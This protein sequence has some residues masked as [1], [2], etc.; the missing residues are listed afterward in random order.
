VTDYHAGTLLKLDGSGTIVQ[1]VAVGTAPE[2]PI[3]DGK[4]IWVPNYVSDSVSV[5]RAS[6]GVVL[7]NLTGN[8]LNR[9]V[10]AAF[11]GQRVLVTNV[12]GNSVSLWKAADL[13]PLG[14][15]STG[16]STGPLGACSDG[17]NF[18]I[19]LGGNKLARF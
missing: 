6:D 18:W 17:L 10:S 9:P 3:F 1:T 11:D 7:A 14:S 2:F 8:G 15:F 12:S 5:V 16:A 13:T 4:S 19:T